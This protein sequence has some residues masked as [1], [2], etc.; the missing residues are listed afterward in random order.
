MP[1]QKNQSYYLYNDIFGYS[2][3]SVGLLAVG[4]RTAQRPRVE[5]SNGREN[6]IA[7]KIIVYSG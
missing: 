4:A 1:R 6:V 3:R 5:N 7:A 2:L